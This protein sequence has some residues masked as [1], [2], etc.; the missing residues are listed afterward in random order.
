[1]RLEALLARLEE[2][3]AAER[4]ADAACDRH[5]GDPCST[6]QQR[7]RAAEHYAVCRSQRILW[8]RAAERAL[9][10]MTAQQQR[11]ALY[12]AGVR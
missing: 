6:E 4:A 12:A 9:E 7:T 8:E 10:G 2:S 3:R 11:A 5:D 1:M